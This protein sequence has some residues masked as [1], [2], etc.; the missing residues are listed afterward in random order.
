MGGFP[1]RTR[2][3]GDGSARA[4]RGINARTFS[5][6]VVCLTLKCTSE[7]SCGGSGRVGRSGV[8]LGKAV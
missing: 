3:A 1:R 4:P 5:N 6:L 2:H 8:R 7:L